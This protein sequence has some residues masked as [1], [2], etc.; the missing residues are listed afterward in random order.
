MVK[1]KDYAKIFKEQYDIKS[2]IRPAREALNKLH[3]E[4][5]PLLQTGITCIDDSITGMK[6]T[7]IMVIGAATNVGKTDIAKIIAINIAEKNL[8]CLLFALE[9][10]N[11]EIEDRIKWGL[12]QEK[13]FGKEKFKGINYGKWSSGHY[14]NNEDVMKVEQEVINGMSEKIKD[15]LYIRYR[16]P[17]EDYTVENFCAEI[18]EARK[19]NIWSLIIVDHLHYF[20]KT[21]D[22]ENKDIENIIKKL[23]DTSILYNTPIIVF[24]HFKKKSN[25][26]SKIP[27]I[28]EFHGSSEI[29][30][31][32]T[33]TVVL[34]PAFD[35][36]KPKPYLYPTYFWIAKEKMK[37][38]S[39]GYAVCVLY[40]LKTGRYADEYTMFKLDINGNTHP[41]ESEKDI[42]EYAKHALFDFSM[43][44]L[45][46]VKKK[47]KY[48]QHKEGD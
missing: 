4:E 32:G 9:S 2:K 13:M 22:N 30:K 26:T 48:S 5:K 3:N 40:N 21:H 31:R 33:I 39:S 37:T 43:I 36:E 20:T 10:P 29:T 23:R 25:L 46:P 7:D 15:N 12:M 14:H 44:K 6:E 28:S 27:D 45:K 47:E 42:P 16:R 18:E 1:E 11:E 17:N 38:G 35:I 19:E 34:T 41:I 24:S 8:N